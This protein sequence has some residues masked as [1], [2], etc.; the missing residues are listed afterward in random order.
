M[1]SAYAQL[2]ETVHRLSE[3]AP[4]Q[5]DN[6]E[7]VLAYIKAVENVALVDGITLSP[8]QTAHFMQI[9]VVGEIRNRYEAACT[10]A[11]DFNPDNKDSSLDSLLSQEA[12]ALGVTAKSRVALIGCG[13][14]PQSVLAY[15][16]L[17]RAVT[18]ID[19]RPEA[20][21]AAR[22]AA[23]GL[24][25]IDIAMGRGETYN[26]SGFGHIVVSLMVHE[27]TQVLEQVASTAERGTRVAVRTV[28][29]LRTLLH[30]PLGQIPAGY[31]DN[32]TVYDS[33]KENIYYVRLLET[34]A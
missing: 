19:N 3:L 8:G 4:P 7:G 29:G 18:G 22:K 27:K 32:G 10:A 17:S 31:R 11:E 33:T 21:K 34:T 2:L 30:E 12:E 25:N 15:A 1:M 6:R 20:V 23:K 26:Y 5:T 16:R 28:D 13:S 14:V 9:S 24:P